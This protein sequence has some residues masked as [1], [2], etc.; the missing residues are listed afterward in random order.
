MWGDEVNRIQ[1]R[2]QV[3]FALIS[4][5]ALVGCTSGG[6][7]ESQELRVRVWSDW[8]YVQAAADLFEEEHPGVTIVVDGIATGDYF[9]TLPQLL[10]STDTPDVTALQVIPG[11]YTDLVKAGLLADLSDVWQSQNLAEAYRPATAARYTTPEGRQY[12]I[13]TAL[14]WVPIVYTNQAAFADAG[15]TVPSDRLVSATQWQAMAKRL[16]A[17]GYVPL[18]TYGISDEYGAAFLLASLLR[19]SCGDVPYENFLQNWQSSVA[20][21]AR[22]TDACAVS[23]ISTID[24]WA[25][26]GIFGE[27]P[28]GQSAE[29]S[30][31]LFQTGKAAMYLSGS[32]QTKSLAT[33]DLS[34]DY[35]WMMLPP[36]SDEGLASNIMLADMDGLGVAAKS[37]NPQLA[38]D[39]VAF[40]SQ[41]DTQSSPA[42]LASAGVSPRS[43]VGFPASIDP[44]KAEQFEASKTLGTSG[45]LTVSVPYNPEIP[46]LLAQMLAGELSELQVAESLDVLVQK[47]RAE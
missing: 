23:A 24:S 2:Q 35:D 15:I 6:T 41:D 22:W 26:A 10:E 25:Q 33:D 9:Q 40:V 11:T 30:L 34:F 1:V 42:F 3:G 13:S 47:A 32:W 38:K 14:Q 20:Q 31:R 37:R 8:S 12:A 5:L 45:Q 28:A 21:T 36:A 27:A 19:S 43:D 18:A 39:F 7:P 44:M 29:N 4:V 17:A 46:R 16:Q